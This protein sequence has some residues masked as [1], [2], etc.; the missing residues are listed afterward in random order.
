[1]YS[2]GELFATYLSAQ[3]LD[4]FSEAKIENCLVYSENRTLDLK[5]HSDIYIPFA[6]V[7]T[8]SEEVKHALKLENADVKITYKGDA[9]CVPAA[10]DIVA[11]I[12]TKN[13]IFNGFF[14]QAEYNLDG[15]DLKITLK[16]LGEKSLFKSVL[17]LMK[18]MLIF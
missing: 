15:K 14:N 3:T 7:N 5:L 6:K 9:F 11:E 8:L 13:V 18:L 1:M 4:I 2:F 16:T 12:R 10:E 17:T